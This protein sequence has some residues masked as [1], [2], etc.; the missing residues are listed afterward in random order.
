[1]PVTPVRTREELRRIRNAQIKWHVDAAQ[2]A[3]AGGDYNTALQACQQ[4]LMLD[5]ESEEAL[6]VDEHAR[7]A[8]EQLRQLREALDSASAELDRGGLTA[9]ANHVYRALAIN[10]ES[11]EAL[12]IRKAIDE[13]RRRQA[14]DQERKRRVAAALA[15]GWE[16]LRA[17]ALSAAESCAAEIAAIDPSN[18]DAEAIRA[19]VGAAG[20]AARR[21]E[22]DAQA[23]RVM[24]DQARRRASAGDFGG[25]LNQLGRFQPAALVADAIVELR[26]AEE[27]HRQQ[28]IDAALAQGWEALK[29]G[30]L[31]AAQASV[32]KV[33][34]SDPNNPEAK[35]LSA[36]I[37][38]A[39][40]AAQRAEA[41]AK[42][43]RSVIVQAR[44]RAWAGQHRAALDMLRRFQPAALVADAIAEL[45][46][47][48]AE[49]ERQQAEQERRRLE[50]EQQRQEEE[51]R[52][53]QEE[54]HRQQEE[55][56]R[57]AE[58]HRLEQQRAE[59]D[60]RRRQ[61]EERKHA[62][63][64][65]LEQQIQHALAEATS[66]LN[67][68]KL[69]LALGEVQRV[70]RAKPD[71]PEGVALLATIRDALSRHD[72]VR[73]T[74]VRPL[75]IG[76]ESETKPPDSP[77][78]PRLAPRRSG[79]SGR[80]VSTWD[81]SFQIARSFRG[82]ATRDVRCVSRATVFPAPHHRPGAGSRI[83]ERTI[84]PRRLRPSGAMESPGGLDRC[85]GRDCSRRDREFSSG[86][87]SAGKARSN[88]TRRRPWTVRLHQ[89]RRRRRYPSNRRQ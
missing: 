26:A 15:R 30:Q 31:S 86:A 39:V 80:R 22:T 66:L 18:Q 48:L 38:L 75:P 50:E 85:G 9:A 34:A 44:K 33:L 78:A 11:A 4:A 53:L 84:Q 81:A 58:A 47:S 49:V 37:A 71:H 51:Q 20:E 46:Q 27:E 70:L 76:D 88:Q 56:R 23:A 45:Q 32:Q 60:R 82:V 83:H 55:L 1:M 77:S 16:A 24:I 69:D 65:R 52:R 43:A 61:E 63:T 68:K 40:E 3:L 42:A 41:D 14:E 62:E 57:R 59:A 64:E 8:V 28:T 54:Q 73:K 17:G 19:E 13:A 35:T 21:A 12:R 72:S 29:A 5:P 2:R 79:G 87:R 10:P 89:L 25:A 74:Q 36:E 67:A 7:D 6:S